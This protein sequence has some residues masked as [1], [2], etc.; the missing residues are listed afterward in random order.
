MVIFYSLI[1]VDLITRISY[2]IASCFLH[3]VDKNLVEISDFSTVASISAGVSHSQNLS[4]LIIDLASVNFHTV[5]EY[6]KFHRKD[7]YFN[8]LLV[9]WI[10][11]VILYFMAILFFDQYTIFLIDVISFLLL[12]IQL[13]ILNWWLLHLMNQL[14]G[15]IDLKF[16]SEKRFLIS[17]L[18]F[19]SISYLLLVVRNL[20][21][22]VLY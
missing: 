17:T 13:L 7:M 15:K 14:F 19:F 20:T 12:A 22:M 10:L 6:N 18:I 1:T 8:I 16:K 4:K 11:I 2:F 9:V 21:L 5:E 3:T